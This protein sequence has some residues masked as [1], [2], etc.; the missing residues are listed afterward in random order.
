MVE[1]NVRVKAA[2]ENGMEPDDG[3]RQGAYLVSG[4]GPLACWRAHAGVAGWRSLTCAPDADGS[5]Y[6]SAKPAKRC[7]LRPQAAQGPRAKGGWFHRVRWLHG[8]S[9][10]GCRRRRRDDTARDW[11]ARAAVVKGWQE[12]VDRSAWEKLPPRRATRARQA[13]HARQAPQGLSWQCANKSRAG[14]F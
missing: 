6:G 4:R 12:K 3:S 7:A 9:A 10:A 8:C 2:S 5:F 14:Q 13:S 11:A 1:K